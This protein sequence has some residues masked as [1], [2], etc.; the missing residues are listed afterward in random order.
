MSLLNTRFSEWTQLFNLWREKCTYQG[1]F[2]SDD[3]NC[4]ELCKRDCDPNHPKIMVMEYLVNRQEIHYVSKG[5]MFNETTMFSY[6]FTDKLTNSLKRVVIP[7]INIEKN[8]DHFSVNLVN[9]EKMVEGGSFNIPTLNYVYDNKTVQ[10]TFILNAIIDENFDPDNAYIKTDM[11]VNYSDEV[12]P[13]LLFWCNNELD[14]V[15]NSS[16][17]NYISCNSVYSI[18]YC[19]SNYESSDIFTTYKMNY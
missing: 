14:H 17:V 5:Y 3:E 12:R 8:R 7:V 16:I 11:V 15:I 6:N 4:D 18:G 13:K 19:N 9:S 1:E 10:D 2:I